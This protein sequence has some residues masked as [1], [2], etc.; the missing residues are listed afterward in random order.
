M[1][2]TGLRRGE[3]LGL[4]WADVDLVAGRL[5]IRR[6]IVPGQTAECPSCGQRHG[7]AWREPKTDAGVRTV[8]LDVQTIGA[9]LAHRIRQDSERGEWEEAYADHQL[10]FARE[11]GQPY[12]PATVT[13]RFAQ[14]VS[15]ATVS[16]V[17]GEVRSLRRVKLHELRH[18]AA[19]LGIAAGVPIEVISKRLGHSSIAVTADIYGHLLSGVGRQA[20]EASAAL[21]PRA[22]KDH[23]V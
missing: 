21:V 15:A 7:L 22:R 16:D 5:L 2:F 17:S 4:I 13:H 19:S 18:G 23:L 20:A 6:Q 1:A 11:D 9:L 10:V 3:A 12:H 8:E 14:L